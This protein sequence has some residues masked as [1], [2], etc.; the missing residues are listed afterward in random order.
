MSALWYF[1]EERLKGGSQLYHKY[2]KPTLANAAKLWQDNSTGIKLASMVQYDYARYDGTYENAIR[3]IAKDK[4]KDSLS[5]YAFAYSILQ[6]RQ[7]QFIGI[8]SSTGGGHALIAN[9]VWFSNGELWISDPNH[10]GNR[11][12]SIHYIDNEFEPYYASL[13]AGAN[14][15]NFEF[16]AYYGKTSVVDWKQLTRR[17]EEAEDG[18]IGR[19]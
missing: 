15:K 18:T 4:T 10:P 9:Q 16:I 5:W 17:W 7:P 19:E 11:S 12:L 8:W 13:D 1:T 3:R 6:T 14:P 2:D